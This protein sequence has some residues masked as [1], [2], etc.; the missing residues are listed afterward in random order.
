MAALPDPRPQADPAT[1]AEME[2]MASVRSHAEGRSEL[3]ASSAPSGLDHV[4]RAVVTAVDHVAAREEIPDPVQRELIDAV[5]VAGVVELVAVCGAYSLIGYM[6]TAFSI[7]PEPGLPT[8]P[9][10]PALPTPRAS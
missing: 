8:L 1:L 3:A 7:E 5:G 6:T 4:A 10:L 9:T 2:R